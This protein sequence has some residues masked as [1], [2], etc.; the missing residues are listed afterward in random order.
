MF[1][2]VASSCDQIVTWCGCLGCLDILSWFTPS[3]CLPCA[4]FLPRYTLHATDRHEYLGFHVPL[5]H[6]SGLI[7]LPGGCCCQGEG[8]GAARDAGPGHAA[9]CGELGLAA[10]QGGGRWRQGH[11]CG[12]VGGNGDVGGGCRSTLDSNNALR[13]GGHRWTRHPGMFCRHPG[14]FAT[15]VAR[16]IGKVRHCVSG[17]QRISCLAD[18]VRYR[19]MRLITQITQPGADDR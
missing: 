6:L 18:S 19:R 10:G 7:P 14:V 9:L 2:V 13:H 1:A 17:I 15:R 12:A 3:K 11:H 8:G 5:F 4:A 16:V